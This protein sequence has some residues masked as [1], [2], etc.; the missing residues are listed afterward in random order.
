MELGTCGALSITMWLCSMREFTSRTA[1][2][3]EVF[4]VSGVVGGKLW[5]RNSSETCKLQVVV[6]EGDG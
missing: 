5:L 3:G 6:G 4:N 2:S 1:H